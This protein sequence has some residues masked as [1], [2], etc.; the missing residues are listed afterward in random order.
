MENKNVLFSIIVSTKGDEEIL[1]NL[2]ISSDKNSELIISDSNFNEETRAW[3]IRQRGKYAKIIYSPVKESSL[4]WNYE[5]L[6]SLNTAILL[7]ENEWV[8]RTDENVEFKDDFFE[9]ARM[10]IEKFYDE[11]KFVILGQKAEESNNEEKFVDYLTKKGIANNFRYGKITDLTFDFSFGIMPLE[12]LLSIN[13]YD[14]RYDSGHG[15]ADM[16]MLHRTLINDYVVVLD[17]QLM[18]YSHKHESETNNIPTNQMIYSITNP[19]IKAGKVRAYNPFELKK[20]RMQVQKMK[21]M[22]TL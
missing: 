3:L 8:I 16:D 14:E 19:E 17:K 7:A 4:H 10:D 1:K 6:Q 20:L 22:W 9:M 12:L 2:F 18:G 11:K 21:G 5:Y 13:G 15:Y